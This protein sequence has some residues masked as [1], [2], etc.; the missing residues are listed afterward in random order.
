MEEA[1]KADRVAVIN[2]G[3]L[4]LDGAPREVFSKIDFLHS[5]GLESPQ[6]TELIHALKNDGID[7]NV[8]VLDVEECVDAI[9]TY[10]ETNR[11]T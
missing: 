9:C 10:I 6:C 1:A 11:K 2:D 5:I 4:V 3:R 8:D 7:V